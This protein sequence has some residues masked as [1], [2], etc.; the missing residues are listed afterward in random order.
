MGGGRAILTATSA[1]A[2]TGIKDTII[3]AWMIIFQN[4]FFI[5]HFP[6]S[7]DP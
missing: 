3:N 7:A 6:L 5:L 4:N 1:P 2:I